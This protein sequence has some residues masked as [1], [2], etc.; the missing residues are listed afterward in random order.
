[1]LNLKERAAGLALIND[2]IQRIAGLTLFVNTLKPCFIC[3]G[4]LS[5]FSEVHSSFYSIRMREYHNEMF[6][7]NTK[8]PF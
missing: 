1:M 5:L 7:I 3:H 8:S 4:T 2:G 6:M